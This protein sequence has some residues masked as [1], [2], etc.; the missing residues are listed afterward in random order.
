LETR[1]LPHLIKTTLAEFAVKDFPTFK[2]AFSPPHGRDN[3]KEIWNKIAD[4]LPRSERLPFGGST[5]VHPLPSG[6][7]AVVLTLPLPAARNEA[8]FLAVVPGSGTSGL[9]LA[10]E[11]SAPDAS[12]KP[13]TMMVG[14]SASGDEL[15][16]ANYGP[17]PQPNREAFVAA[18]DAM[19]VPTKPA[20]PSAPEA[21]AA[22]SP[23]DAR[24]YISR[25]IAVVK[26]TGLQESRPGVDHLR[27]AVDG[28]YMP[29][30]QQPVLY[31]A[32]GGF[33]V[34]YAI[35]R[36]DHFVY[37]NRAELSQAG[38]TVEQLHEIGLKNLVAQTRKGDGRPG[39]SIR[40]NGTFY[41]VLVGGYFEASLVL[42]DALWNN[43][44]VRQ[45]TPNGCIV[46][47]PARDLL[48]FCDAGSA[49]GIADLKAFSQR[50][51]VK[52]DH[53][54]TPDLFLCNQG[55]WSKLAA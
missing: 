29:E 34:M 54:L 15:Q 28:V 22:R 48:A 10:L 36:G 21:P 33:A 8:Y 42:V 39:M 38:M 41:A 19:L 17:G 35:D 18:V 45:V 3:F 20:A 4:T 51:S 53:A 37:L 30:S 9:V 2:A 27:M 24:E 55:Q 7:E 5:S 6:G 44:Q 50:A 16:R 13:T 49:Q 11:R 31:V 46:A 47:M 14:Y 1:K 32:R 52:A 40:Q 23:E 25:A 26:Q 43:Q 12:G